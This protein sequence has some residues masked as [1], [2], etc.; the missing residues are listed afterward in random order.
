MRHRSWV[1]LAGLALFATSCYSDNTWQ[2]GIQG[3]HTGCASATVEQVL[4]ES[5]LPSQ[6]E[7]SGQTWAS[8]PAGSCL[9]EVTSTRSV[10]AELRVDG[11]SCD[12]DYRPESTGFGRRVA[13]VEAQASIWFS[14]QNSLVYCGVTLSL[15]SVWVEGTEF[16]NYNGYPL[17]SGYVCPS[18]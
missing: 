17:S 15:H 13:I 10:T 7:G 8:S 9:S 1:L 12:V 2:M 3:S 16:S 18:T 11:I 4:R 5:P 14:C 6:I